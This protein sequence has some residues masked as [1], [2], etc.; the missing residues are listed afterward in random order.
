MSSINCLYYVCQ[1][2]KSVS[3]LVDTVITRVLC[4]GWGFWKEKETC[5]YVRMNNDITILFLALS[6][7][8]VYVAHLR[9]CPCGDNKYAS[10]L[11]IFSSTFKID[12]LCMIRIDETH[13][14]QDAAPWLKRLC[15]LVSNSMLIKLKN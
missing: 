1:F 3:Y 11:E 14:R 6:S 9:T 4:D 2:L 13:V 7:H 15:F 12:F 8:G 5:Q 10:T